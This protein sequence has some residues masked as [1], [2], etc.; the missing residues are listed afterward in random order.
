MLG[1]LFLLMIVPLTLYR[2]WILL[3]L[4]NWFIIPL[5]APHITMAHALGISLVIGFMTAHYDSRTK[6]QSEKIEELIAVFAMPTIGLIMG[7]IFQAFM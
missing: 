5:G 3:N 1:I 7:W 6:T 2:G 4:W